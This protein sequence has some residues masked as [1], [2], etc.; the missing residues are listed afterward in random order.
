MSDFNEPAISPKELTVFTVLVSVMFLVALLWSRSQQ[1]KIINELKVKLSQDREAHAQRAEFL[2]FA[3]DT[4]SSLERE[5]VRRGY[6]RIIAHPC[7]PGDDQTFEFEWLEPVR[8]VAP[9]VAIR[10][11]D[12][13]DD[14]EFKILAGPP[15]D[16]EWKVRTLSVREREE[17][18]QPRRSP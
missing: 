9:A 4:A 17:L 18:N 8:P 12:L 6:G 3:T 13:D 2:K 7:A 15:A 10:N 14:E 5:A 1:Q 16:G 11:A